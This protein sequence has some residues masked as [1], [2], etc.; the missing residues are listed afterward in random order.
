M[1]SNMY[2]ILRMKYNCSEFEPHM[3]KRTMELMIKAILKQMED[4]VAEENQNNI[5]IEEILQD[6]TSQHSHTLLHASGAVYN[7]GLYLPVLKTP[8]Y[9]VRLPDKD[10]LLS[11]YICLTWDGET[12]FDSFSKMYEEVNRKATQLLGCGWLF[13]T[14][15]TKRDKLYICAL[16]MHDNP[17]CYTKESVLRI[18]IF[19]WNLWEHAYY[20]QYEYNRTNYI[21]YLWT[22]MNW[23]V[24]EKRFDVIKEYHEPLK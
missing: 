14:Y 21:K 24:V 19:A 6:E 12:L 7:F 10:S 15:N 2:N 23:E 20:L 4:I 18:P 22:M 5:P 3:M 17:M 13:L 11:K 1:L 16:Q 9:Q 8:D